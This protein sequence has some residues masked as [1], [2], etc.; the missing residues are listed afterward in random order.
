MYNKHLFISGLPYTVNV[1]GNLNDIRLSEVNSRCLLYISIYNMECV[2]SLDT[3]LQNDENKLK[4]YKICTVH[5][6]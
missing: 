1:S 3:W 5:V 4:P 6:F 2:S